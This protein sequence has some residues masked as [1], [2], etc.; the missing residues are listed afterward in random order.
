MKGPIPSGTSAAAAAAKSAEIA[1][2]ARA[3]SKKKKKVTTGPP[4]EVVESEAEEPTAPEPL[5]RRPSK[6]SRATEEEAPAV[7]SGGSPSPQPR[8]SRVRSPRA[9]G[10]R[11]APAIASDAED[12]CVAAELLRGL[13][14]PATES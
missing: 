7:V 10:S 11:P 9:E 3:A 12:P 14:V 13:L 2:L 4:P 5:T 8:A 6:R 1:R